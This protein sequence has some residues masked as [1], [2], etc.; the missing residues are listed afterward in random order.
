MDADQ[1]GQKGPALGL[2]LNQLMHVTLAHIA[3]QS[4]LHLFAGLPPTNAPG[5][6]IQRTCPPGA[7][8]EII[9]TLSLASIHAKMQ[10]LS[11]P[12]CAAN[13]NCQ[14]SGFVRRSR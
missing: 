2:Y 14:V 11:A 9:S 3:I 6:Q 12:G 5:W 4:A 8:P 7:W 1:Q 13:F 10:R